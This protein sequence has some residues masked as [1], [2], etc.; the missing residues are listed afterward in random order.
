MPLLRKG[1]ATTVELA[2]GEVISLTTGGTIVQITDGISSNGYDFTRWPVNLG[3]FTNAEM[4]T[5][6]ASIA[7]IT[8]TVSRDDAVPMRLI[9]VAAGDLPAVGEVGTI[10]ETELG[11]YRWSQI[12]GVM[13]FVG[14][15]ADIPL[16]PVN[17]TAPV[18]AGDD[19][20]DAVIAVT[21]NGV[22]DNRPDAA[23]T[24]Q[25]QISGV[26]VEGATGST[27]VVPEA[28]VGEDITCDVTAT[29]AVGSTMAVSNFISIP[30]E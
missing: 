2:A 30:G 13:K 7:D 22:W 19:E 20:V 12:D 16:A 25:W 24:Y 27:F 10:Y 23:F 3:P 28:A 11:W 14:D 26:D 17:D 8:Y 21:S 15:D 9:T 29:N 5:I 18:I 1:N 4:F 6:A